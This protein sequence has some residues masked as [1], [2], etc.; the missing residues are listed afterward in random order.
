MNTRKIV[1]LSGGVGGAKLALGLQSVLGDG[2]SV[3]VNVGDD[4][5]HLGLRICPDIDT[6]LYTLSGLSD[7]NRGWGRAGET[8]SFMEALKELGAPAWFLLGDKDLAM[9]VYRTHALAESASL[10]N[11]VENMR[12]RLSIAANVLPVTDD[13]LRTIV[14]TPDGDLPFQS[15]FVEHRCEPVVSGLRFEGKDSASITARVAAAIF[16]P[17]C[18]AIVICPS[19]PLLSIDP[20]LAVP[21]MRDALIGAGKPIV[22]VSPLI[23]R[24]A[25]K[26][27]T[28]KLMKE[29]GFRLDSQSIVEH[30]QGLLTGLVIDHAD[31]ED[32]HSVSVPTLVTNT[33]MT[34]AASKATL[35][36]DVLKFC[37]KL[38]RM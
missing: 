11:V 36:G 12:A 28:A 38:R 10:T 4:F 6:V 17:D 32:L 25:V 2:L 24:Q 21:G 23:G 26:G 31:E 13:T 35:A 33:L 5:D 27:P 19:N 20:I 30:Y 34:D 1:A 3:I 18:E 37:T 22:A 9:H 15:Y 7:L 8:W 14:S 16:H 29:F